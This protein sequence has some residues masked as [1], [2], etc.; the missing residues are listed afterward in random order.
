MTEETAEFSPNTRQSIVRRFLAK[1]PRAVAELVLTASAGGETSLQIGQWDKEEILPNLAEEVCET[2]S[3]YAEGMN[4][5]VAGM[6]AFR[7]ADGSAVGKSLV[8]KWTPEAMRNAS[9]SLLQTD[10]AQLTGTFQSQAAQAQRHAEVAYQASLK[11]I[12]M[13]FDSMRTMMEHQQ[14][15]MQTMAESLAERREAAEEQKKR[16]DELETVISTMEEAQGN[17]ADVSASQARI[18]QI[19]ENVAPMVLAKLMG[20]GGGNTPPASG[21]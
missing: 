11:T 1:P 19:V 9:A 7:K 18:M 17:D 21:G 16:A 2:L 15:T 12:A 5:P 14:E 10:A 3:D 20:G 6:L 4:T 8:M 13:M